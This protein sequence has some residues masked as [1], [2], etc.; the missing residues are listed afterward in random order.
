[1]LLP[2]IRSY[3]ARYLF[4]GDDAFKKVSVLSG[5]ERGRLAL[6]KLALGDANVLLLDEPTNHLDIPSQEV[7]QNVLA[8][9]EGTVILVS[10]DRY[11]IDALAT[12]VWEIDKAESLLRV[13]RGTYSEYRN[14]REAVKAADSTECRQD[15]GKAFRKARA[16]KNREIAEE[17]RRKARLEEVDKAIEELERK[18]ETLG[19]QLRNPPS[20]RTQVH[21]IGEEYLQAECDL[22]VLI[23]EWEKLQP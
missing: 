20:D 9:F 1:M 15:K 17:R 12:Q 2:E 6:A 5:G 19:R 23:E 4:P 11:L 18:L 3:L 8:D 7:L 16:A 21:R 22:E 14:H 10:H 13:Y